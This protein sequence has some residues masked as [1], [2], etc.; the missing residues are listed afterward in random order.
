VRDEIEK[1]LLQQQRTKMQEQWVKE[2]RAKAYIR[3]F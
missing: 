2:L 3:L 1:T